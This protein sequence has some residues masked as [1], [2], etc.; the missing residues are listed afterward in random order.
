MKCI[1]YDSFFLIGCGC[2]PHLRLT[3]PM[4][5]PVR[6]PKHFSRSGRHAAL[7]L[8]RQRITSKAVH[9]VAERHLNYRVVGPANQRKAK[10]YTTCS[11]HFLH[12]W[13]RLWL[14]W[15]RHPTPCITLYEKPPTE[16]PLRPPG[17]TQAWKTRLGRTCGVKPLGVSLG[18]SQT[19]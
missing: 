6:K 17:R 3:E 11:A 16:N 15:L 18:S 2:H 8:L 12:N 13:T 10:S 7:L 19:L 4:A 9:A 5:K 14:V 1:L